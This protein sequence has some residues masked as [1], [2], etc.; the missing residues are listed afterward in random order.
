MRIPGTAALARV[1]GTSGGGAAS[2]DLTE[3]DL[4]DLELLRQAGLITDDE[5]QKEWANWQAAM[6]RRRDLAA[7][8]DGA[9]GGPA[10]GG[11]VA[12][13]PQPPG[14]SDA[15]SS[16]AGTVP[17]RPIAH[18][19][20]RSTPLRRRP[21]DD[22][23]AASPSTRATPSGATPPAGG[24]ARPARRV[25]RR[26][27]S[28]LRAPPRS[29]SCD[30]DTW[31]MVPRQPPDSPMASSVSGSTRPRRRSHFASAPPPKRRDGGSV[32]A[33]AAAGSGRA[34]PPLNFQE[35]RQRPMMSPVFS[36]SSDL[37]HEYDIISHTSSYHDVMD[38]LPPQYAAAASPSPR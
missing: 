12:L 5:Y 21:A 2:P 14:G 23:D 8:G 3:R 6:H 10:A 22:A 32:G 31:M 28:C 26:D 7:A 16:A 15:A 18:G 11:S 34:L 1:G 38:D 29:A 20:M 24:A 35:V 33:A 4:C 13:S 36:F 19:Q 17:A 37:S 27:S 9:H 25:L 30:D